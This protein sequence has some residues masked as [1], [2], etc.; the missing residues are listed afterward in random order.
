MIDFGI[1]QRCEGRVHLQVTSTKGSPDTACTLPVLVWAGFDDSGS[2]SEIVHLWSPL[3]WLHLLQSQS[4][5]TSHHHLMSYYRQG[6]VTCLVLRSTRFKENFFPMSNH[7]GSTSALVTQLT[8][9]LRGAQLPRPASFWPLLPAV[10]R[11]A[12]ILW[13]RSE[14]RYNRHFTI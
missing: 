1:R 11:A 6:H 12:A 5:I 13:N 8:L 2:V 14:H 3:R 7:K 4:R 10:T 9:H